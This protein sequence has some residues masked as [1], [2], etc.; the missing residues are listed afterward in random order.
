MRMDAHSSEKEVSIPASWHT[1]TV[2]KRTIY[3]D[4][5]MYGR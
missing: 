1:D 3:T 5:E 4:F 2:I